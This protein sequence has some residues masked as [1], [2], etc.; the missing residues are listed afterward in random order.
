MRPSHG[1][2]EGEHRDLDDL[3]ALEAQA[4][5]LAVDEQPAAELGG[6][7]VAQA[8]RQFDGAQGA[9][10]GGRITVVAHAGSP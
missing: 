6:A 2:G 8:R 7:G 4:R 5:G 3:V 10:A 1:V 9:R